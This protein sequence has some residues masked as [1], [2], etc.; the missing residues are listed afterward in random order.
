MK[1]HEHIIKDEVNINLFFSLSDVYDV[2]C[3]DG[4]QPHVTLFNLFVVV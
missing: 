3:T 2:F 1:I 4:K